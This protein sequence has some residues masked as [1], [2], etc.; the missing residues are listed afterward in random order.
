MGFG[1][2]F[3]DELDI[4]EAQD[5]WLE[6]QEKKTEQVSLSQLN[7]DKEGEQTETLDF[8]KC[9]HVMD[10]LDIKEDQDAW[11]KEQE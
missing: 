7:V 4:E 6:E 2:W 9:H 3:M 5:V 10:D 1:K 11:L 8:I